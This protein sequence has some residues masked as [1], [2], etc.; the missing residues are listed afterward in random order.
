[1]KNGE[2]LNPE[3]LKELLSKPKLIEQLLTRPID[4]AFLSNL[5]SE[6]AKTDMKLL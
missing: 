1:M 4:P 6:D 3:L 2:K 5:L